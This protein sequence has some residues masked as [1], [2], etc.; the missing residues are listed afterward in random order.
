MGVNGWD[1]R[2]F[3]G[4]TVAVRTERERRLIHSVLPSGKLFCFVPFKHIVP[5]QKSTTT[6]R[7]NGVSIHLSFHSSIPLHSE[8]AQFTTHGDNTCILNNKNFAKKHIP[9]CAIKM[10]P[11][12]REGW[13]HT[14]NHFHFLSL[15]GWGRAGWWILLHRLQQNQ[16]SLWCH[17]PTVVLISTVSI[18]M[19]E[20]CPNEKHYTESLKDSNLK[21]KTQMPCYL[22]WC[23]S[24][25]AFWGS[26]AWLSTR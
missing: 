9:Q 16:C 10:P 24:K 1:R 21:N 6:T 22:R 17:T 23:L 15:E 13:E 11:I 12:S 8:A 4:V 26:S 25:W 7:G 5:V 20:R 14:P 3:M 18:T 2:E 19:K